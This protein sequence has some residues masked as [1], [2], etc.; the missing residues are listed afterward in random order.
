MLEKCIK[1]FC[2]FEECLNLLVW[3]SS[4]RIFSTRATHV[5]GM[6]CLNRV[7]KLRRHV[8]MPS[9]FSV[10]NQNFERDIVTITWVRSPYLR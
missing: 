1:S 7:P 4:I 8:A 2:D 9:T 5:G 6:L 10:L 3:K